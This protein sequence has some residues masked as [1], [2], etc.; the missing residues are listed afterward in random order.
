MRIVDELENNF[1]VLN[2]FK[3]KMPRNVPLFLSQVKIKLSVSSITNFEVDSGILMFTGQLVVTWRDDIHTWTT[4]DFGGISR[5]SVTEKQ[6]WMPTLRQL[7]HIGN[8]IVISTAG[9]YN[10]GTVQQILGGGFVAYC[11]LNN[12]N[13]PLDQQTCVSTIIATGNDASE[14]ELSLLTDKVDMTDFKEHGSWELVNPKADIVRLRDKDV[15]IGFVAYRL[16]LTLKRRPDVIML[17]TAVP[18]FLTAL[19]NTMIYFVP[20][21]SGERIS[22]AI[23]IL[24][25]F[26]FFTTSIAEDIPRTAVTT[27]FVSVIMAIMNCLCTLNVLVSVVFSRLSSECIAPVPEKLKRFTRRVYMM[28]IN[29][30]LGV[31]RVKP[32]NKPPDSTNFALHNASDKSEA[33]AIKDVDTDENWNDDKDKSGANKNL[34]DF[35]ITWGTLIDVFDIIIF[36]VLICVVILVGIAATILIHGIGAGPS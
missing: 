21:R 30:M 36:C 4:A 13:W 20:V 26:V 8:E 3:I 17:H 2:D 28:K 25:T 22:F 29:K 7:I 1:L 32:A 27:P 18:I 23:T 19:L 6:L 31:A 5:L 10:N 35:D 12:Y 24:L 14:L 33:L 9:L 15:D 11:D 16:T 34:Y